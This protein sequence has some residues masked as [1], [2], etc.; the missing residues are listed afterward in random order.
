MTS[1][2]KAIL[3]LLSD[4]RWHVRIDVIEG[5]ESA[6]LSQL[7]IAEALAQLRDEGVIEVKRPRPQR[8]RYFRLSRGTESLSKDLR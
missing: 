4:R 2:R 8:R 7:D 3:G 6:T 1:A 5:L